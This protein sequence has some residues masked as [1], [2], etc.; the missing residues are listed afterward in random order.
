MR[1]S[2]SLIDFLLKEWLL[3][4]SAAGLA[5]TS[6]HLGRLPRFSSDELQVLWI[7]AMLFIAVKG[8][9]KS[10]LTRNLALRL[11]RG[12]QVP[13]KLVLGTFFLSMVITNDVALLAMVPLTLLLDARRKGL[14]VILE[15]LAANAG[16]ALTPFGNPQNLFIY[17]HYELEPLQFISAIAPFSLFFGGLLTLGALAV[18]CRRSVP[19]P[20]EQAPVDGHAW[21]HGML[22][23]LLILT[24]LHLLPLWTTVALPAYAQCH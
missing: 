17:W 12:R 22:L 15:A 16:S 6:L 23:I 14:L 3:V 19:C 5:A 24:V 11:E 10:G 9:E 21:L 8:V 7:L 2:S 20:V 1:A 18:R 4:V 13:L